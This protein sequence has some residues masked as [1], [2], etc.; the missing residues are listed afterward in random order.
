MTLRQPIRVVASPNQA[1]A[2]DFHL[3]GLR[4]ANNQIALLKIVGTC[5]WP[6][7]PPLHG[8]FSLHHAEFTG[9]GR[10]IRSF[11]KLRWTHGRADQDASLCSL[12][13][14]RLTAAWGHYS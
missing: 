3:M 6:Q 10:A 14:Q 9:Q 12:L 11:R 2:A 1:M 8:V 7:S 4:E 13:L 5:V